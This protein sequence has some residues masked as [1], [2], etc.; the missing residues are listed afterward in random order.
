[1]TS[2][3]RLIAAGL[4]TAVGVAG[5]QFVLA[6]TAQACSCVGGRTPADLGPKQ[7]AALVTRTAS[8]PGGDVEVL[9]ASK[10]SVP[11]LISGSDNK[12]GCGPDIELD[13]ISAVSLVREDDDWAVQTCGYLDRDATFAALLGKPTANATGTP[14]AWLAGGFGGARVAALN[15]AGEV[16]A[17]AEPGQASEIAA[18]PGGRRIV[19]AGFG[20]RQPGEY[21]GAGPVEVLVHDARTLRT[22]RK[23]TLPKTRDTYPAALR[24]SDA[25]GDR[26]DLVVSTGENKADYLTITGDRRRRMALPGPLTAST[27]VND[28]FVIAVGEYQKGRLLHLGATGS[29][30]ELPSFPGIGIEGVVADPSG[31]RV[32]VNGYGD[33]DERPLWTVEVRTGK[34]LGRQDDGEYQ[35]AIVWPAADRILV[36]AFD[37]TRRSEFEVFDSRLRSTATFTPVVGVGYSR[38]AGVEEQLAFYGASARFAVQDL[39]VD[40]FR[41]SPEIRLAGAD[42]FVAAPGRSF[43]LPA[44]RPTSKPTAVEI[45]TMPLTSGRETTTGPLVG[46]V[47]GAVA[48]VLALGLATLLTS[49]GRRI[50][51]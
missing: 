49:R 37:G 12:L 8:T 9:H 27:A 24:C 21:V 28:A 4:V 29:L 15:A 3:S 18:C 17:W 1:M 10:K 30:R 5:L 50:P 11:E 38:L 2:R 45:D 14:V 41:I 44:L 22:V 46:V 33:E 31:K 19:T 16:T 42:G 36:N 6:G 7:A 40:R 34:V 32:L 43:E 26:I 23:V 35:S 13:S 47:G 20:V 48:F 25:T 51:R 39:T